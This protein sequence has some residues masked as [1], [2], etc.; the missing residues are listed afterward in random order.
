MAAQRYR[1]TCDQRQHVQAFA[2]SSLNEENR[3]E[4]KYDFPIQNSKGPVNDVKKK[5][6]YYNVLFQMPTILIRY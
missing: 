5:I 1:N 6:N 2:L 3:M 4:A